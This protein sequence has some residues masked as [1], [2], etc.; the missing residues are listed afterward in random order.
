MGS[1][2]SLAKY[3]IGVGDRF[4]HQAKPQPHAC[5]MAAGHGVEVIPDKV[6]VR[7]WQRA[8]PV[9]NRH[10]VSRTPGVRESN[11]FGGAVSR[12]ERA[13]EGKADGTPELS[14]PLATNPQ[15]PNCTVFLPTV[16]EC[17]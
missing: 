11:V 5:R 4:A 12:L 10:L 17:Q 13:L 2:L 7:F 3:S 14:F 6:S 9:C 8:K 15:S 16:A 1:T